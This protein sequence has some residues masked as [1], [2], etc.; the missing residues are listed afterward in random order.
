VVPLKTNGLTTTADSANVN[1]SLSGK[2][3][4]KFNRKSSVDAV[5]GRIELASL[6][7]DTDATITEILSHLKNTRHT[8]S[9]LNT[10]TR[11]NDIL[12]FHQ[13]CYKDTTTTPNTSTYSPVNPSLIDPS[14]VEPSLQ[15]RRHEAPAPTSQ[16]LLFSDF[17]TALPALSFRGEGRE[18]IWMA[19]S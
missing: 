18:S 4:V 13:S 14:L 19:G 5:L 17:R 2:L 6:D 12:G 1:N 16:L 7:L 3:P 11:V 10:E 15:L 8:S 9:H